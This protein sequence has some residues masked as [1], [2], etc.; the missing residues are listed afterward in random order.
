[1]HMPSIARPM[2]RLTSARIG[3]IQARRVRRAARRLG[4]NVRRL[5]ADTPD[6][7]AVLQ[8]QIAA[9]QRIAQE[10]QAAAD[11]EG[12]AF[13]PDEERDYR[14]ARDQIATITRQLEMRAS[15]ADLNGRITAPVGRR[16]QPEP[17]A[18]AGGGGVLQPSVRVSGVLA[19]ARD[20][21]GGFAHPGEFFGAVRVACSPGGA[22]DDRLRAALGP[23]YG[24][25]TTGS[26]G[27]YAV[28][29][30]FRTQIWQKVTAEPSLLARC[31]QIFTSTNN[32]TLPKDE[33][34]PWDDSA[35]IKASWT[36]EGGAKPQ[37]KPDLD[38]MTLKLNKLTVLVPMTD[39]L[40]DDA[41]AMSSYVVR[42]ASEKIDFKVS[43]AI[44]QGTGVG[45]PQGLLTSPAKVAVPRLQGQDAASLIFPNI[46]SMYAHLTANHRPGAVWLVHPMVDEQ[47]PLM[48]FRRSAADPPSPV[49]V[50]LPANSIAGSP[51][52]TLYGR[53][54][55]PTEVCNALGTE[56]DIIFTNLSQYLTLLKTGGVRQDVS[57]HVYFEN[58][59]TAFRFVLRIGGQSWWGAPLAS[60]VGAYNTSPYVTLGAPAP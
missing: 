18:A 39:E 41:A 13:T 27:G 21:K 20:P 19:V 42:K 25:E 7:A 47:L 33:L 58:D 12:R 23:D 44:V 17:V 5:R 57:I 52:A 56:G 15:M 29:P 3:R 8:E 50:Y 16:S 11:A 14:A 51:Y 37:S 2:A 30:D 24:N 49:P 28:P 48:D 54:V 31:D 40:L 45:Q 35:G 53:P 34:A 55:I 10:I 60:R 4:V 26:D 36:G 1:M 32:L 6:P 38:T 22:M 46:N 59:V 9:A 43:L